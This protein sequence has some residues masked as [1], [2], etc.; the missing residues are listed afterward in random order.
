MPKEN[1]SS[2]KTLEIIEAW[3]MLYHARVLLMLSALDGVQHPQEAFRTLW[4]AQDH[5]L[6]K[7]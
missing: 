1:S 5:L 7:P 3:R 4:E 2:G 6:Q